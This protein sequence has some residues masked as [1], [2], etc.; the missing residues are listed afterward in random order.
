MVE[1]AEFTPVPIRDI[2][3]KEAEDFTPWLAENLDRLGAELNI[4]FRGIAQTEVK[5]GPF[6]LDLL[7]EDSEGRKV[8]IENQYDKTNHDH[9]GK[10]LTYSAGVDASVV[11][12][13]VEG[14]Q[15]EH[16]QALE[17]LNRHTHE[18]I[19][20]FAVEL[21]AVKI[22][23]SLPVPVFDVVERPNKLSEKASLKP[24]G[25]KYHVFWEQV[26]TELGRNHFLPTDNRKNASEKPKIEF[27]HRHITGG[28][29]VGIG[30]DFVKGSARVYIDVYAF[31]KGEEGGEE[32]VARLFDILGER[33]DRFQEEY[34][35]EEMQ[36]S[37]ANRNIR[38]QVLGP[39]AEIQD[40][41][42]KLKATAQWM[43]ESLIAL[44]E[45]VI[46]ILQEEIKSFKE[47]EGHVPSE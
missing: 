41:E 12:W 6:R 18:E 17:W 36:W 28:N 21:N 32:R 39:N 29:G 40:G 43:V 35:R 1:L 44:S 30:T 22:G 14:F 47:N 4:E 19:E 20:F 45:R 9:L 7:A 23:D 24:D 2:W 3:E 42:S 5:V 37:S 38:I 46:P 13:L 15:D 34:G 31:K 26:L 33:Q 11:V 27:W 25:E 8:A 16:R 10:L